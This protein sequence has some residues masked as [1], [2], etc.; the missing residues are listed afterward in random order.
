MFDLYN[1][2]E[3]SKKND[4]NFFEILKKDLYKAG[5]E[6]EK[7]QLEYDKIQE[8]SLP[9]SYGKYVSL[10]E[11]SELKDEEEELN[12][13]SLDFEEKL[14]N[15]V[16]D[17][18]DRVNENEKRLEENEFRLISMLYD[19]LPKELIGAK[20]ISPVERKKREIERK[21]E[22]LKRL[23]QEKE[24][25]GYPDRIV[26]LRKE[27]KESENSLDKFKENKYIDKITKPEKTKK[28]SFDNDDQLKK[29]VEK[30]RKLKSEQEERDKESRLYSS[31][32]DI[33]D[34]LDGYQFNLN[35]IKKEKNKIKTATD[36]AQESSLSN[37]PMRL[38]Q[39]QFELNKLSIL[40]NDEI[41]TLNNVKN[42]LSVLQ[43][44][45]DQIEIY[46]KPLIGVLISGL[47]TVLQET[48]TSKT[49]ISLGVANFI[50]SKL[51]NYIPTFISDAISSVT[52][53]YIVY[54]LIMIVGS[55]LGSVSAIVLLNS[56]MK[57]IQKEIKIKEEEKQRAEKIRDDIKKK[58]ENLKI[59]NNIEEKYINNNYN[60]QINMSNRTTSVI[61]PI[62]TRDELPKRKEDLPLRRPTWAT[63]L[64]FPIWPPTI[65]PP[66]VWPPL[67]RS[68]TCRCPNVIDPV[69]GVNGVTY[70]NACVASCRGMAVVKCK[71]KEVIRKPKELTRRPRKPKEIL[72]NQMNRKK[73]ILPLTKP[74]TFPSERQWYSPKPL[75]YP[76]TVWPSPYLQE[77]LDQG[78]GKKTSNGFEFE[79]DDNGNILSPLSTKMDEKTVVDLLVNDKR[80]TTLVSLVKLADLVNALQTTNNITV[81]APTNEAF[82]KLDKETVEFLQSK[83]GQKNLK[84][85]LLYHVVARNLKAKDV[86]ALNGKSTNTLLKGNDLLIDVENGNVFLDEVSKVIETDRSA[87]NGTIHVIDT[88]LLPFTEDSEDVGQIINRRR[89][90]PPQRR[91]LLSPRNRTLSPNKKVLLSPRRR[92]VS[93]NRRVVLP[94]RRVISPNR[95]RPRRPTIIPRIRRPRTIPRRPV[96]RR[97]RNRFVYSRRPYWWRLFGSEWTGYI[98][99]V[100][101]QWWD[102][103]LPYPLPPSLLLR[104]GWWSIYLNL[105]RRRRRYYRR[106]NRR[107]RRRRGLSIILSKIGDE[108]MDIEEEEVDFATIL[109]RESATLGQQLIDTLNE[110]RKVDMRLEELEKVE[111]NDKTIKEKNDLLVKKLRLGLDRDKTKQSIK[112]VLDAAKKI[113]DQAMAISKSL[114]MIN[115]KEI[116]ESVKNFLIECNCRKNYGITKYIVK[117]EKKTEK[118]PNFNK[119]SENGYVLNNVE[120]PVITLKRGKTYTFQMEDVSEVNPF[121]ISTN[122][123]GQGENPY[124]GNEVTNQY[125]ADNEILLFKPNENTPNELYYQSGVN[126]YVGGKIIIK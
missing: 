2:F 29:R 98:P 67:L 107:P 75:P 1:N 25:S 49:T 17:L 64:S 115:D 20:V 26:K 15:E 104:P 77:L 70:R 84:D 5:N 110:L 41:T 95:R 124:E 74:K 4:E 23:E 53:S 52:W 103:R 18:F 69:C 10:I 22:K 37:D 90:R 19:G 47:F 35:A 117:I 126:A 118:H 33:L 78:F 11:I 72:R 58:I 43:S 79:V 50:T 109:R 116:K 36:L 14:L 92:S 55:Q 100:A 48:I 97:S 7:K 93:P 44:R 102:S 24:K 113:E 86:I 63:R 54:K 89:V 73:L 12:F 3:F 61:I 42:E 83:Q 62:P 106:M 45:I 111:K 71:P 122:E 13:T 38:N 66:L 120:G 8:D 99:N 57:S 60:I 59:E 80:F 30:F 94:R 105:L 81:F 91:A 56:K 88:V 51:G 119:G 9:Q 40:L 27:I 28:N 114:L 16:N 39:L 82:S 123:V 96:Y 6:F 112:V 125:A 34:Q 65:W 21:R 108:I 68:K 46:L 76:P 101:P 87:S 121:Y 31:S 32:K 85:I